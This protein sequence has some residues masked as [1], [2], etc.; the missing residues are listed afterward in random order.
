VLGREKEIERVMQV[1]SRRTP[2]SPIL[3]GE[4]GIGKT[5]AIQGLA[6]KISRGEV[7]A[8]FA[9]RPIFRVNLEA[10][11]AWAGEDGH[12]D[13][14]AQIAVTIGEARRNAPV[15]LFLD[16]LPLSLAIWSVLAPALRSGQVQAIGA[17]TPDIRDSPA[18][19]ELLAIYPYLRDLFI[20]VPVGEL[21]LAGTIAVLGGERERYEKYHEV[22]ISDDAITAMAKAAHERLAGGS[23]PK[24]AIGLMDEAAALCRTRIRPRPAEI[25]EY[26]EQITAVVRD[27]DAAI[28]RGDSNN[29]VGTLHIKEQG[30]LISKGVL[31]SAWQRTA[32]VT[33]EL[34]AE[35][36]AIMT[37]MP[38][39]GIDQV[40]EAGQAGRAEAGTTAPGAVPVH[41]PEIW[42]MA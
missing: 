18:F 35:T 21:T 14:G 38:V 28:L 30:L 15:I 6:H 12:D 31:E 26:Q 33:P 11:R 2:G 37:G 1:L 22:V 10:I 8:A 20:F 29:L 4:P 36:V 42:S 17:I 9:S 41:D 24:R 34:V 7:P 3:V 23:L 19:T 32:T 5:A 16:G 40:A 39:G 25:D 13:G 27:K